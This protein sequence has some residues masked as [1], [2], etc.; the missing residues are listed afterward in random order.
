VKSSVS[1]NASFPALSD[2]VAVAIY[3]ASSNSFTSA[4]GTFTPKLPSLATAPVYVLPFTSTLT[5]CPASIP[6]VCPVIV[7]SC[8]CSIAFT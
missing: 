6:V 1:G 8:S 3:F 5:I 4:A 7:K 2:T